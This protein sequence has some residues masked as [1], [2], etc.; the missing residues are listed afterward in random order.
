M[1]EASVQGMI[2]ENASLYATI[3]SGCGVVGNP[4]ITRCE[5]L[6]D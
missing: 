3:D 6:M 4:R 1:N 2:F 5:R